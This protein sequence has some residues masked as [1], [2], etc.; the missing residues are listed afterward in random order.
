MAVRSSMAALLLRVRLLINDTG[1]SPVFADQDIQDV[2][3]ETRADLYNLACEPKVT[4]SGNTI[5]YLTYQ[6]PYGNWEADFVLKQY[7]TV[8]VTPA[9]A[10]VIPGIFTFAAS[11][12]PPVYITGKTYDCY[13]TAADL[14]ERW[15]AKLVLDFDFSSDSQSFR[16][17]QA[18]AMLQALAAT[19]RQKQRAGVIVTQRADMTGPGAM[20]EPSLEPTAIDYMGSG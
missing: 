10:E 18:P 2:M 8:Q 4:F 20:R 14:L 11:T 16:R 9:T 17:S 13:R 15:A 3:D 12:F 19:Y 5:L 1:G 6:A 7:L